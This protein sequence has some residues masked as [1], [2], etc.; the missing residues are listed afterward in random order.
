M[1]VVEAGDL[2]PTLDLTGA[3][4]WHVLVTLGGVP[5]GYTRLA[6]P[7]ATT[8][9]GIANAAV[10][11]QADWLHAHEQF[12][13]MFRARLGVPAVEPNEPRCSVVICTR[14]RSRICPTRS[15]RWGGWTRPR[16]S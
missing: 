16:S 5:C 11:R 6:S 15:M 7:G 8:N 13:E 2:L 3:D 10:V 4:D 9:A 12:T 14:R 1:C